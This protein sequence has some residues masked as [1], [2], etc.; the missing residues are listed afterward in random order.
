MHT[1]FIKV[2]I[3]HFPATAG[4]KKYWSQL[5]F[6][7]KIKEQVQEKKKEQESNTR[8]NTLRC[9]FYA[10]VKGVLIDEMEEADV[11]DLDPMVAGEVAPTCFHAHLVAHQRELHRP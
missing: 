10:D 6:F 8:N 11:S 7:T 5:F 3:S 2:A 4:G 1:G 9:P